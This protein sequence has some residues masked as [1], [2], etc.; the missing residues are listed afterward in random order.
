MSVPKTIIFDFDGTLANS[1][2][3]IFSLY[4]EHAD[5]YGYLPATWEEVPALRRM[6]YKKAM[7]TKKIKVRKLPKM[8]LQ[9]GR[10]MRGRMDEVQP[11]EGI[12][13]V[14]KTLRKEGHSI[15]VLT[16]NQTPLVKDFFMRHK[17][18]PFDFIV[19]EKTLFGKDKA[20]KRIMK[21]HQ[22]EPSDVLYVGDEP[23][24]VTASHKAGI[25]IV[26]VSWGLPGKEGFE[27]AHPDKLVHTR[28]GL[29]KAI[30]QLSQ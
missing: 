25:K 5:E 2:E 11:Y 12:V 17:F 24:D 19:S 1:V 18:P 22:L 4:N 16:S 20:L 6:G 7:R 13:Q 26:G 23:R 30:S 28:P 8:F 15:G 9:I 27:M 29:T 21:R 3:L 10:E 14:L